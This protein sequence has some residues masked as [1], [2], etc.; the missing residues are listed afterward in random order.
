MET[1]G[2]NDFQRSRRSAY[3][4]FIL[5]FLLYMFDYIDRMVIVSL[6]PFLQRDW[7]LSDTPVWPA[8]LRRLLVYSDF[9][10]AR[11]RFCRSL[12]QKKMHRPDGSVLEPGNIVLCADP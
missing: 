8:C 1:K 11:C 5:L 9:F 12:E 2:Q 3:T 10:L 7:G 6:F 4:I